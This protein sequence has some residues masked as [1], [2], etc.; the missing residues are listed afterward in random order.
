MPRA[1]ELGI[2]WVYDLVKTPGINEYRPLLP[3]ARTQFRKIDK[4]DEEIFS[5]IVVLGVKNELT[6]WDTAGC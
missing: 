6:W 5:V 3:L 2:A 1:L 4:G